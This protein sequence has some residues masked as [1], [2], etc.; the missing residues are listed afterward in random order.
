MNF[1]S[2]FNFGKSTPQSSASYPQ[3]I[4]N[5]D[6]SKSKEDIDWTFFL[7][8]KPKENIDTKSS[9]SSDPEFIEYKTNIE[10]RFKVLEDK[11][12][13]LENYN[14]YLETEVSVLGDK[15][16]VL[17]NKVSVLGDKVSVLAEEIKKNQNSRELG[18]DILKGIAE[19]STSRN[20][21]KSE[22]KKTS[23]SDSTE[24]LET[25]EQRPYSDIDP[26]LKDKI[27]KLDDGNLRVFSYGNDKVLLHGKTACLILKD[28]YIKPIRTFKYDPKY[29][30]GPGWV[31]PL[32][33]L[34][35]L[36]RQVAR[37]NAT[38]T[39]KI[40]ILIGDINELEAL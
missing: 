5:E 3:P 32:K 21:S 33:D 27:Y 40:K 24:E 39:I 34:E 31:G 1:L 25:K 17:G 7:D 29:P 8:P 14:R 38:A 6:N 2:R 11:L 36:E 22:E 35:H 19:S 18:S 37:Y 15:V 20:K 4:N 13:L 9:I 30:F 12:K 16:S 28:K 26:K 10:Q 23:D